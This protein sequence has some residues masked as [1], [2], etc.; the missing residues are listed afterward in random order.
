MNAFVF[1]LAIEY[2][3]NLF[4]SELQVFFAAIWPI[5]TPTNKATCNN[6]ARYFLARSF[7]NPS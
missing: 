6:D 1:N 7:V 3:E 5:T 4:V 2:F